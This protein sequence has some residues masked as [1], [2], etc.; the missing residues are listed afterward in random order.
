MPSWAITVAIGILQ[1]AFY[2]GLYVAII[3]QTKKDV[4]ELRREVNGVG[5]KLGQTEKDRARAALA[6]CEE[7]YGRYLSMSLAL[8]A[9]CDPEKREWLAKFLARAGQR[10]DRGPQ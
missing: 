9:A 10:P 4:A 6:A 2:L 8:M 1:V 5:G 7:N 3:R